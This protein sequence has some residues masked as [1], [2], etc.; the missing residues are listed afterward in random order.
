MWVII[1][2]SSD[3]RFYSFISNKF[4]CYHGL[5]YK[6]DSFGGKELIGDHDEIVAQLLSLGI[7]LFIKRDYAKKE[8]VSINL[9]GFKYLRLSPKVISKPTTNKSSHSKQ[10]N[11]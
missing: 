5:N 9:T 6:N 4:E 1:S 2:T 11:T 8:A 3:L 7:P 10:Q